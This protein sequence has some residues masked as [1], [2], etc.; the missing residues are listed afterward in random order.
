MHIHAILKYNKKTLHTHKH[1]IY[2]CTR[3]YTPLICIY[4]VN[5]RNRSAELSTLLT[6]RD[7]VIDTT[8]DS[9][10]TNNTYIYVNYTRKLG[11]VYAM[12]HPI[13]ILAPSYTQLYLLRSSLDCAIDADSGKIH[14]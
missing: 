12:T 14:M 1:L 3:I 13:R 9:A 2:P 6:I 8:D 5:K 10:M 11:Q 4:R 7:L